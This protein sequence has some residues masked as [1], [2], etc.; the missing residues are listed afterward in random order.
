MRSGHSYQPFALDSIA[1]SLFLKICLEGMRNKTDQGK[2][3]KTDTYVKGREIQLINQRASELTSYAIHQQTFPRRR[4]PCIQIQLERIFVKYDLVV[5]L[6]L[7]LYT[8][9]HRP[10]AKY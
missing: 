10:A 3:I 8:I 1:I 2:R 4:R 5:S 9:F 6:H 7:V